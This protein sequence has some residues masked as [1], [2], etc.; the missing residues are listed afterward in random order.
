MSAGVVVRDRKKA[1]LL[2]AGSRHDLAPGPKV[3]QAFRHGKAAPTRKEPCLLCD[4]DKVVRDKFGREAACESCKGQGWHKVDPMLNRQA[5][6]WEEQKLTA[7]GTRRVMCDRCAGAGVW[8]G[9]RCEMCDGSGKVSVPIVRAELAD[10]TDDVDVVLNEWERMLEQREASGSYREYDRC[11]AELARRS[12]HRYRVFH[13]VHVI[14]VAWAGGLHPTQA[15]LLEQAIVNLLAWMPREIVV[16]RGIAH[17]AKGKQDPPKGKHAPKA[18]MGNRDSDMLER[19]RSGEKAAAIAGDLGLHV[20]S[21]MRA[22]E[23]AEAA[24]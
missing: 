24:A 13:E 7:A 22:L 18:L 14:K 17:P 9:E 20:S 1:L 2:L 6:S 8:K 16:P 23:R 21:V 11:V 10:N 15:R 12:P 19:Y 3:G 4:G 5:G